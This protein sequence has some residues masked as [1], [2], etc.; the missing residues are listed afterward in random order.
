M[1]LTENVSIWN[2]SLKAKISQDLDC[3]LYVIT[4]MIKTNAWSHELSNIYTQMLIK[5]LS[6]KMSK[7]HDNILYFPISTPWKTN[8]LIMFI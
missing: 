8:D 7:W 5:E 3:D 2:L 1:Q 6:V 4:N